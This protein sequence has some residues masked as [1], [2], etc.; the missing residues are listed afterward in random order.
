[1]SEILKVEDFGPI[2]K[3]ELELK[4]T[5]VLIGPQGS[6]KSTLAKL[7]AIFLDMPSHGFDPVNTAFHIEATNYELDNYGSPSSHITFNSLLINCEVKG[8]DIVK[9]KIEKL[10]NQV[11][12][13]PTE[14]A[15]FSILPNSVMSLILANVNLPKSLTGFGSNYELARKHSNGLKID[16]L[17]V[18]YRFNEPEILKKDGKLLELSESASGYQS[19]VPIKI[20]V[21][22]Y[23]PNEKRS[24]IIEE[25]EL[26]LY[27]TTQKDLIYYLANRCAK[28]DNELLMTTHSPYV[29]S[30]LNN[31]LFAYQV[32]QKH[33]D[34]ADDVAKIIPKES[35]LNPAEFAAY[36]V[37]E[38]TVRSI[39]DIE[40]GLISDNELDDVS[41]DIAGER[42]QLFKIYRSVIRE[43]VN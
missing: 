30:A 35:W 3:A 7:V 6:G 8:D 34:K 12:F 2:R 40:T 29:L 21:E 18:E 4:K 9:H 1:M 32:A 33:P 36:Y 13:I 20:V 25:P 42:N 15:L 31:L 38:G 23:L 37:G 5:T 14:R 11:V 22:N 39:F 27:P 16:Y 24:F 41:L 19:I 17:G 26:N 28:G 10:A 43:T